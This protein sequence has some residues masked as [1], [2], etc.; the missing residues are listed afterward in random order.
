MTI[1]EST[2]S[3]PDVSSLRA[4]FRGALVVP[5]EAGWESATQAFNLAFVQEPAFVALPADEDDV[6]AVVNFAREHGMQ[7][8]PQRTGHNALHQPTC[9]CNSSSAAT[10]SRNCRSRSA[11]RTC[12]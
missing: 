1:T 8:A 12:A 9:S 11:T 3:T 4:R 10:Q 7:V 5:G 6:I 2:R